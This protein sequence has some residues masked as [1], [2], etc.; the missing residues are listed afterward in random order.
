M[1]Y[2]PHGQ[3]GS[4]P[5]YPQG[6]QQ[7][8]NPQYPQQP[9]AG[10][11]S[12]QPTGNEPTA[13]IV[14]SYGGGTPQ[15]GGGPQYGAPPPQS[16]GSSGGYGGSGDPYSGVQYGQDPYAG[17]QSAG[18]GAQGSAPPGSVPPGSAPPGSVPPG[19]V[20]PYGA[21][22][23]QKSRTGLTI[24]LVAGG[25][26]LVLCLGVGAVVGLRMLG[27]DD[28]TTNDPIDIAE[29][30]TENPG[31]PGNSG[32]PFAGTPAESFAEGA[33]GIVMPEPA[34]VGDF[35]EGEVADML[36]QVREAMIATRIDETMLIEHDP[37]PFIS[38]MSPDNQDALR[39]EFDTGSFAYFATQI[40]EGAQLAVPEP[41]VD[42]TVTFEATVDD[43][44]FR[45]I[46]VVTNFVW[47]YA[48]V[49]PS[50]DVDGIVV[51][52]DRLVWQVAHADD[53]ADSSLGLWLW[54]GEAYASGIDC[55]AFDRG[56]LAPQ[57][58]LQVG[59]GG[60]VDEDDLFDPEGSLDLPNNC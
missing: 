23:Q 55:D 42:G 5:Q 41:R 4:N 27:D 10:P 3:Y 16:G 34:A 9:P 6:P 2:D 26:A 56:Y 52:R 57:S 14:P 24:G 29:P 13:P 54:E 38:T 18:W 51:V 39:R 33:D 15:Y 47:A 32:D 8:Q 17:S 44:G 22:P 1:T 40:E 48:F 36:E 60:D 20:P 50:S 19:S 59:I 37:E 21:P 58:E 46:E 30:G 35:S 31:D 28:N 7:P 43:S 25:V 11:Y 49:P 53:V 45:V 12:Q